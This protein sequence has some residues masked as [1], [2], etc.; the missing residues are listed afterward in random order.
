MPA[1]YVLQLLNM[2]AAEWGA[3]TEV[4]RV[5]LTARAQRIRDGIE[6]SAIDG[7]AGA[8]VVLPADTTD[9]DA[10]TEHVAALIVDVETIENFLE[11]FS[12]SYAETI[13]TVSERLTELEK[14]VAD[15]RG[16]QNG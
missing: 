7:R 6:L 12:K 5:G 1:P 11:T 8:G 14:A 2:T 9:A 16:K 15:L 13:S 10:V 3:K 4:E